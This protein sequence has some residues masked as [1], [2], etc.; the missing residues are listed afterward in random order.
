VLYLGL[1][2]NI[3]LLFPNN[4]DS[5]RIGAKSP[6]NEGLGILKAGM[7][8]G[9]PIDLCIPG[10]AFLSEFPD[11]DARGGLEIFKL[12]ATTGQTSLGFNEQPGL[13]TGGRPR[14]SLEELLNRYSGHAGIRGAKS[15]LRQRTDWLSINRG[16]YLFRNPSDA[17]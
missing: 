17:V 5:E 11:I 8:A 9:G 10:G 7:D 16:F 13:R 14:S 4:A 3:K 12:I 15:E 2:K 1:T 6:S